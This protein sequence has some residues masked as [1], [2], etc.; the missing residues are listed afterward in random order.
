MLSLKEMQNDPYLISVR[1]RAQAIVDRRHRAAGDTDA[2]PLTPSQLPM[3][4]T[5]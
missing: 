2:K 5:E 3:A 4:D 1:E